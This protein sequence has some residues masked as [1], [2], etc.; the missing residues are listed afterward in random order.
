[1]RGILLDVRQDTLRSIAEQ[2]EILNDSTSTPVK[3][4]RGNNKVDYWV[5]VSLKRNRFRNHVE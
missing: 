2:M 1:M 4:A 5:K 3:F